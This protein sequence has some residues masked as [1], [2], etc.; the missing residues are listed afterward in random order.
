M[1]YRVQAGQDCKK[2]QTTLKK[3][4]LCIWFVEPSHLRLA[5][6]R[7]WCSHLSYQWLTVTRPSQSSWSSPSEPD[8]PPMCAQGGSASVLRAEAMRR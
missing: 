5:L 8:P 2:L 6:V 3:C 1:L 7:F 4:R